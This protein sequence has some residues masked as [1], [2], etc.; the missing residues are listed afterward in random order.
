LI[1]S[2][3]D[4]KTKPAIGVCPAEKKNPVCGTSPSISHT[5]RHVSGF[6]F[7]IPRLAISPLKKQIFKK[8]ETITLS[9]GDSF[10]FIHT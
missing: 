10:L 9:R 2:T 3:G 7:P 5:Q 8:S 6:S 4:A 1:P